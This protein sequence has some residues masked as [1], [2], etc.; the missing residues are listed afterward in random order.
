[1][2]GNILTQ[3]FVKYKKS[4]WCLDHKITVFVSD[5]PCYDVYFLPISMG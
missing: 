3:F 5:T 2:M 4:M 1:M